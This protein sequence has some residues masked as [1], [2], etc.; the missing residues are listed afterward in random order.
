VATR[1]V[2]FDA[3]PMTSDAVGLA[4]FDALPDDAATAALLACCASPA[5][6]RALVA[7][8]PYAD[9]GALLAAADAALAGLSETEIDLT[10][11]GHPRIGDRPDSVAS[12][13]EQA[14]V[15]DAG[16]TVRR[17]LAEGNNA[18]EAKFGFR[19]LVCASG[20]S[21]TELLDLL[22]AR[23]CNDRD[24]ERGVMRTEL[25]KINRIRLG[26]MFGAGQ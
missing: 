24:T 10:L 25:G 8:R 9:L 7:G 4:D 3:G 18:Y 5:L 13:R 21:G 20:R 26:R 6:A 19:Y 11:E 14:G 15:A 17:G 12:A 16:D 23:L 2:V 22:T 1:P